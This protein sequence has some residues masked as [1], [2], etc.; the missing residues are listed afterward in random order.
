VTGITVCREGH[1]TAPRP[2]QRIWK[3]FSIEPRNYYQYGEGSF[4]GPMAPR[5]FH[6]NSRTESLRYAFRLDLRYVRRVSI[7]ARL[8]LTFTVSLVPRVSDGADIRQ[9]GVRSV[10]LSSESILATSF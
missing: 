1:H 6:A 3:V 9:V 4:V 8:S 2:S 10:T 5:Y 7:I